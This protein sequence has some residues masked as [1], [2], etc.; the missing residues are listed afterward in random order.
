M[1]QN[2]ELLNF[3]YENAQM[4]IETLPKLIKLV[5]DENFKEQLKY[6]YKK[7]TEFAEKAKKLLAE[8]GCEEKGVSTMQKLQTYIMINIQTLTDKSVTHIAE[9][10]IVGSNMG[11]IQAL[12]RIRQFSH[13]AKKEI[14]DFMYDLLRHE[15]D[16]IKKL[17]L[18]I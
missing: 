15:E 3:I 14:L 8:N 17:K 6:Q 7:Y 18:F 12:R 5:E 9:M 13:G 16:N 10:L 4:G 11:V 2:Q 1:N